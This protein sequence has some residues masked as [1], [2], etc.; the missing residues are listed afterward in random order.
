MP[1]H[2]SHRQWVLPLTFLA[3]SALSAAGQT[4]ARTNPDPNALC[5][6]VTRVHEVISQANE[7]L[8]EPPV[9]DIDGSLARA[10]WRVRV[11]KPWVYDPAR[12]AC[13]GSYEHWRQVPG[14]DTGWRSEGLSEKIFDLGEAAAFCRELTS[15]PSTSDQTDAWRDVPSFDQIRQQILGQESFAVIGG[16]EWRVFDNA[17]RLRGM[18]AFLADRIQ[19]GYAILNDR[20]WLQ[21]ALASVGTTMRLDE[22]EA[23]MARG[24]ADIGKQFV[25]FG[26]ELVR[27]QLPNTSVR[28][29]GGQFCSSEHGSIRGTINGGGDFI[30]CPLWEQLKVPMGAE[31]TFWDAAGEQFLK[32]VLPQEI[33][34]QLRR[35]VQSDI[36]RASPLQPAIRPAAWTMPQGAQQ[37]GPGPSGQRVRVE[38]PTA[39]V[40]SEDPLPIVITDLSPSGTAAVMVL[41]GR[42]RITE[43]RTGASTL[44]NRGQAVL[45]WPGAG[46]S[47][48]VAV[49]AGRW[50]TAARPR[51][52]GSIILRPGER[53]SGTLQLHDLLAVESRLLWEKPAGGAYAL[54]I[55]INGKPLTAPLFNKASP[56]RYADG[57]NFPY[58]DPNSGHWMAF[59]SHDYEANKGPAAG[60]YEV[61]TE[62][63]QAYRYV[64]D[65][66]SLLGG[67]QTAQV[68]F[69]NALNV[70]SA[71][72][73]L[74]LL[75]TDL[76]EL[77]ERSRR[78]GSIPGQGPETSSRPSQPPATAAEQNRRGGFLQGLVDAAKN[79]LKQPATNAG[80]TPPATP[81]PTANSVQYG[82][83]AAQGMPHLAIYTVPTMLGHLDFQYPVVVQ[84][85]DGAGRPMYPAANLTVT[86]TSS[87]PNLV[88][89]YA[90]GSPP[91]TTMTLRAP[92]RSGSGGISW[93]NVYAIAA[94]ASAGGSATLTASAPGLPGA[95][96]TVTV[97]PTRTQDNRSTPAQSAPGA[98]VR[99]TVLPPIVETNR[100]PLA[101]IELLDAQGQ[102]TGVDFGPGDWTLESSNP[103]VMDGLSSN[104][105]SGQIGYPRAPGQAQLTVVP[106][107]RGVTGSTATLTAVA[108]GTTTTT[109]ELVAPPS[110]ARAEGPHLAISAVP[111]MLGHLDF[112]YPVVVQLQDGSGRPMYPASN[113]T[114]TVTSSNPN[115]VRVYATGS[116]PVTTMTLRAPDRS[117]SGGISWDNVYAIAASASAGGSATLTA[118]APGLPGASVT[119]TVVPTRTQDNRSTPAQSA[120]G[121]RVRLTVLPPIVE[122]N[123]QPLASIELL[124]AQGQPTGVDFGPGDW[125]L[126]SSNPAVM[127]G[128]SS[129][130]RSGQIGYP[131][132]PGQAQLTVV[133]KRR[134]VTGSTATL[135]VVAPGTT[136]AQFDAPQQP[137]VAAGPPLPMPAAAP[138]GTSGRVAPRSDFGEPVVTGRISN[139]VTARD[140]RQ[141]AAVDITDAFSP[142]VNPIHVWFRLAGFAP[143]TTLTS[144]WTYLGGSAPQVIGTGEFTIAA[145]SDYGTFNYELAAGKRWPAGDYRI[146]ILRDDTVVGVATFVVTR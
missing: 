43:T 97:V 82:S 105:R 80:G 86:V 77:V 27:H 137:P 29:M 133:P 18:P 49:S 91:V 92:D 30:Y 47:R 60:V 107:R 3:L 89:V 46:V 39:T 7:R 1:R 79:A 24:S 14:Q 106:K 26:D 31:K 96:V 112:Q 113:L 139:I 81:P 53:W 122:T 108:P 8:P 121:A 76:Y 141:G 132:A 143:G 127:D 128:L 10:G 2:L 57:R 42:V 73:E 135:T 118:S 102:P 36:A 114:V 145:T 51:I 23:W 4:P 12:K 48:P 41:A 44:A 6:C 88:R 99:L 70:S 22:F 103:A 144:R 55:T 67:N 140:V 95:S 69:R 5:T 38:L 32:F 71:S 85:Q 33:Y 11:G 68:E 54:E 84:L 87:N 78:G 100:Q 20:A 138:T 15:P 28:T 17:G 21:A 134:G 93:D 83:S 115:L 142:D 136:T 124:D 109:T 62:P 94:S 19:P 131:R 63:S 34:E 120:P 111:T 125:T 110:M 116:P 64:W 45:V 90:T 101:S 58:R 117:G 52:R 130:F 61:K 126:E 119:V 13:V 25:W 146:E 65:V 123:R 72:L 40:T 50:A 35:D 59:Y 74:R 37:A 75:P 56:M 104:F 98:R 9:V 66:A 16:P 129:N